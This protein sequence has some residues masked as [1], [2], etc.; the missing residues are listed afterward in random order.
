MF[1]LVFILLLPTVISLEQRRVSNKNNIKP[2]I[3][4]NKNF[5]FNIISRLP[6]IIRRLKP[7]LIYA[8]KERLFS[9]ESIFCV[10]INKTLDKLRSENENII[11]NIRSSITEY[12]NFNTVGQAQ[13]IVEAHKMIVKRLI[14]SLL[15][16]KSFLIRFFTS[17]DQLIYHILKCKY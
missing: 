15:N 7:S 3:Y 13:V 17:T 5:N 14:E 8:I 12:S 11:N 10:M 9:R 2:T 4:Q 16:G 1:I 6:I